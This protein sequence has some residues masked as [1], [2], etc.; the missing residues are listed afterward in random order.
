M[1]DPTNRKRPLFAVA[2]ERSVAVETW[3]DGIGLIGL[4]VFLA[5]VRRQKRMIRRLM[6]VGAVIGSFAGMVYN[7]LKVPTFTASSELLI[8]NTTLQ[9]SGPDAAVTQVLVE[10]SLVQSAIEMLKSS[11]V[12]ERVIDRMG[13]ENIEH[14]L[15]KSMLG[16][17]MLGN[18]ESTKASDITSKQRALVSLRSNTTAKRV[19]ASL[20]VS[21]QG[22][23]LTAQDA[24]R[25]ADELAGAFVQEQNETSAVVTTSAA[26]RERIKVLGPTA[27][28]ISEAVPPNSK[29]G[30]PGGVALL[31]A[32]LFGSALGAGAGLTF[33]L[34]DRRVRSAEQLVA[35][36]PVECFGYVPQKEL[37]QGSRVWRGGP[38]N[39]P[40][41]LACSVLRRASS[42]VL[43]RSTTIP[44]I[45][46]VT[47]C[48]GGEGKTTLA[49]N[50]AGFI[51]RDGSRVL[52]V[53]AAHLTAGEAQGLYELLLGRVA[54]ADV[55]QT[56]I[57]PNVDFLPK[58]KALSNLD[59]FWS[60]LVQAIG[61]EH[62]CP[63][64]WVILDLPPLVTTPD[65]RSAGQIIDDLLVVVEWGRTSESQIEQALRSLGPVRDRVSG[66][67]INKTPLSSLD[68]EMLVGALAAHGSTGSP[69]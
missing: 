6:L 66:T 3:R 46:G 18:P 38:P 63:Y 57:S 55:V 45:I 28:I 62:E 35:L 11:K 22:K 9:M 1:L 30:P 20:I 68:S 26:L 34:F 27:R 51:A 69:I 53:E 8:S 64:E 10:N 65:V 47:S 49:A 60:N 67:L 56:E 15:P 50:W 17:L 37:K 19:G 7:L 48:R 23:A 58:G 29:D 24:V 59:M 12:L 41:I 39:L 52:F 33:T 40:S 13:L 16:R 32:A 2:E 43:E 21:V 44:H 25:L 54:L 4:N 36:T 42:A 31:L 14:I 61:A 5:K